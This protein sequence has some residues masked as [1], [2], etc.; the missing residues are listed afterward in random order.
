MVPVVIPGACVPTR[1]P[2]M[3]TVNAV[4]PDGGTLLPVVVS[5][6]FPEIVYVGASVGVGVKVGVAVGAGGVQDCEVETPPALQG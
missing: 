2:T 3:L 5:Y 6:T 1:A 4:P